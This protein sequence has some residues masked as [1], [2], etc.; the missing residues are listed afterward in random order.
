MI[1][2]VLIIFL[3]VLMLMN[4]MA[5]PIKSWENKIY[6]DHSGT[7]NASCWMMGSKPCS[8]INLA[9]SGMQYN[10]TV[11]YINASDTSYR[12]NG[13]LETRLKYMSHVAIVGLNGRVSIECNSTS[14]A[15]LSFENS[16]NIHLEN[17]SLNGCGAIQTST[18]NNLSS[19][20]A[21]ALLKFHVSVYMLL[22][23]DV[24]LKNV[25]ISNTSGVGM[26]LY[27]V[28][29]VAIY[30][31]YFGNN[32][33]S[34]CVGLEYGGGGGLQIE[35]MSCIPQNGECYPRDS[36]YYTQNGTYIIENTTFS[37]NIANQA[38]DLQ[39][40]KMANYRKHY[41][42]FGRGG[43]LSIVFRGKCENF[44]VFLNKIT[45]QGNSARFGAGF[46]IAFH[47]RAKKNHVLLNS[48]LMRHNY[49]QD[50][51]DAPSHYW[52][53]D[54]AG[55]GGK[56]IYSI[57]G[58]S[59]YS[60]SNIVRIFHCNFLKNTAVSG[61]GLAVGADFTRM[62]VDNFVTINQS[63]FTKNEAYLGSAV[64]LSQH[65]VI[66]TF[67]TIE[68]SG[69]SFVS[70]IAVCLK[71]KTRA[72]ASV[73]CSGILYVNNNP[74]KL[75]NS[76]FF[77]NEATALEVHGTLVEIEE[78]SELYFINNSGIYGGAVG[79][80]DCSHLVLYRNTKLYFEN[81]HAITLGGAIYSDKCTSN[82]QPTALSSTCF[83]QYFDNLMSPEL[84]N[85][86]LD[87]HNNT[88]DNEINSIYTYDAIPCWWPSN[89]QHKADSFTNTLN[90]TFCWTSW[91]Y[92]PENCTANVDSPPAILQIHNYSNYSN[93]LPVIPGSKVALPITV[94]N[95]NGLVV[96]EDVHL[97]VC[98]SSGPASLSSTADRACKKVKSKEVSVY[99]KEVS[100]SDKL[101]I[102]TIDTTTAAPL[103]T[104]FYLKFKLCEWPYI[105]NNRTEC[106]I[107][108]TAFCCSTKD[109]CG[110]CGSQCDI[111]ITNYVRENFNSCLSQG[112]DGGIV[113]GQCPWM[114]YNSQCTSVNTA[115]QQ[116]TYC[117]EG[118]SGRLCGQC[119]ENYGVPL[120][121]LYLECVSC[122]DQLYKGWL[123]LIFLQFV[124]ITILVLLILIL[125]I[126]LTEGTVSGF[127]LFSQ[128]ISLNLPG[129]FYPSW[130]TSFWD[131]HSSSIVYD[132][133]KWA[134][135]G[136][137]KYAGMIT[138]YSMWN[139]NFLTLTFST[140][141]N[142]PVCIAN[143][144]SPLAAISFWYVVAFYPL[145][146]L[147]LLSVCMVVYLRGY[148]VMVIRP[149][150][151]K[152]ARVWS[153]F[154]IEPSLVTSAASIYV[155]CFTQF[156]LT[157]LKLL[158]V[159][160][161]KSVSSNASGFVFYYDGTLKYFS[162]SHAAAGCFAV[163]ILVIVVVLP[164]L[165]LLL[166][167]FKWFQILLDKC[168]LRREFLTAFSDTFMGQ[169]KN[170]TDDLLDCRYF[171]GLFLLLRLAVM[172]M[173]LVPYGLENYVLLCVQ[174][175][176]TLGIAGAIMIIRPY[177]KTIHNFT[178]F[179]LLLFLAF[180][181]GVA[182]VPPSRST[183][184]ILVAATYIPLFFI[185]GYFAVQ[186]CRKYKICTNLSWQRSLIDSYP[187][188]L[189]HPDDYDEQ[190]VE[191]VVTSM[192]IQPGSRS[193]P[194]VGPTSNTVRLSG[195]L[196][197]SLSGQSG[198]RQQRNTGTSTAATPLLMASSDTYKT[199]N[200]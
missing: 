124:P 194:S 139:L 95:G 89:G 107:D 74:L 157:S 108:N 28:V 19:T 1:N 11:I 26:T 161:W 191:G 131:M 147:T 126:D 29:G 146:L 111:D 165:Y 36:A 189:L 96:N 93:P 175:V 115:V 10:S 158:N 156:A 21:T 87:F 38:E 188:R 102:I 179:F 27:N 24:L 142:F 77:N 195:S 140:P 114:Y 43:G 182:F 134:Y 167:P 177:K 120:N 73:P 33:V 97:K 2:M 65:N 82:Y 168:R 59:N 171:A 152:L 151:R 83:I 106:S 155:L 15:G 12:L 110:G 200:N 84:W 138:P 9:L 117:R 64:S 13:G 128:I 127:V 109:E 20:T 144:L 63:N 122:K 197:R 130:T 88:A 178:N 32:G 54:A 123:A 164:M 169:F 78:N 31:S 60:I 81:N 172:A 133:D 137:Y 92:S 98:I 176:L 17:M 66:G 75:A 116:F 41:Y 53:G 103:Q 30:D 150:H 5:T 112:N 85:V 153:W 72:F 186:L 100:D 166:Y 198:T 149:I 4:S 174:L 69:V 49:N 181:S 132:Q 25:A 121:A 187:D 7:D 125:K 104:S 80:Y 185:L 46:Y 135:S 119:E 193:G 45:I 3:F 61:G 141:D 101:I 105:H 159:S 47:G 56:I 162:G 51:E 99:R 35:F 40:Y 76:Y 86:A 67:L 91:S 16:N 118:R 48:S 71:E 94:Y 173:F 79:L 129:W 44:S 52:T 37:N 184:Y 148:C 113:N 196:R 55:G 183:L 90:S 190:H 163:L 160:Q 68:I 199:I 143:N 145:I 154:N 18:S 170:G 58:D 39:L 50:P 23:S 57:E 8:N 62:S 14:P 180:L 192:D 136:L 6:V 42:S 34:K 70:N 22:C